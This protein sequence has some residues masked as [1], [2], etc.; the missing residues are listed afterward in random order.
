M[1]KNTAYVGRV[2]VGDETFEDVA[3]RL[4]SDETFDKVQRVLIGYAT[5]RRQEPTRWPFQHVARCSACGGTSA[6]S[7]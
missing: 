4:V 1:L 3:P 5:Q 2:T 6:T 7:R